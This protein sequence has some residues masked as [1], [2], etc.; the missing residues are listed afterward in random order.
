V[1]DGEGTI[2]D[3]AEQYNSTAAAINNSGQ[4]VGTS[5]TASG[6]PH[7]LLWQ[8]GTL[9]DLGTPVYGQVVQHCRGHQRAGAGSRY[10]RNHLKPWPCISVARRYDDGPGNV[11][12]WQDGRMT[13][14]GT[15]ASEEG[16]FETTARAINGR[17][18]VVGMS[19]T[20]SFETHAF[21]WQNGTMTDLGTLG[22]WESRAVA[23]NERGQVVGE[24][25]TASDGAIHAFMWQEGT[26]TD[27]GALGVSESRAKAINNRGQVVGESSTGSSDIHAF[28]WEKGKMTDLGSLGGWYS[29]ATAINN[30]GQIVGISETDTGEIH[31][32]LWEKGKMTD[33]GS[34]GGW[35]SAAS[36]INKRG[37]VVGT[38][39]FHAF[40]WTID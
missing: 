17:G 31:A 23:I 14:L 12:W 5:E 34:L 24:S 4:V 1:C 2:Q 6:E 37:Q 32:F 10:K 9:M 29:T 13:D 7:A 21:L 33:L 16:P 30:R 20:D 28:L 11:G 39:A 15:L 27:L 3:K 22:G 38:D 40:L 26:M 19:S 25:W 36:A 8:N 18:Q 35:Y